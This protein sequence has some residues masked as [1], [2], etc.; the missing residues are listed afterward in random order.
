MIPTEL[1]SII[2]VATKAV[3]Q[4]EHTP[5]SERMCCRHLLKLAVPLLEQARLDADLHAI[6]SATSRATA[7]QV[8]NAVIYDAMAGRRSKGDWDA[9]CT[10]VINRWGPASFGDY[11]SGVARTGD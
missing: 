4:D 10:A 11:P 3:A 5:E 7:E 8:R 1:D 2:R 9:V 6:S